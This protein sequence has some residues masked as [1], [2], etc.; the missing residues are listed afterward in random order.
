[1]SAPLH[2]Y[3][4]PERGRP[5]KDLSYDQDILGVRSRKCSYL[6]CNNEISGQ[7]FECNRCHEI[8]CSRRCYSADKMHKLNCK[9]VGKT[10]GCFSECFGRSKKN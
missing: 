7:T 1:M 3:P 9:A 10:C 4:V 5:N 8:Y 6:F 2:L